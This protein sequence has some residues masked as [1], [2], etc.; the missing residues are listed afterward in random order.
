MSKD[1]RS[2][3]WRS[4]PNWPLVCS[5]K[6]SMLSCERRLE[7]FFSRSAVMDQWAIS[8]HWHDSSPSAET[9]ADSNQCILIKDRSDSTQF[10]FKSHNNTE[11]IVSFSDLWYN[12]QIHSWVCWLLKGRCSPAETHLIQHMKA[13]DKLNQVSSNNGSLSQ[14]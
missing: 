4:F 7:L 3:I 2:R 8:P 13:L 11:F 9:K 12:S 6:R 14:M 5:F 1:H 10:T